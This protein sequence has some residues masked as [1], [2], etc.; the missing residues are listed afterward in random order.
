MAQEIV[1]IA[2]MTRKVNLSRAKFY[3]LM[4][5]GA[6]PK[7]SRNRKTKRPFYDRQGQRL[8]LLIVSD[9]RHLDL[10]SKP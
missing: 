2:A 5:E 4:R 7:P 1:T 8:C 10:L 3:R 9:L 6:I